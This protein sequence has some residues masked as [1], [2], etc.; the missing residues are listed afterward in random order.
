ME[1]Y[2]TKKKKVAVY[3]VTDQYTTQR[4]G[5]AFPEQHRTLTFVEDVGHTTLIRLDREDVQNLIKQL[6]CIVDDKKG[7]DAA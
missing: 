4:P 1:I 6:S 7:G 5:M 2:K 3:A